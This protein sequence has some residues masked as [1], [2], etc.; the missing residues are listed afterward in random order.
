MKAIHSVLIACM[1][2]TSLAPVARADDDDD[3]DGR[4]R[5]YAVSSEEALDLAAAYGLDW[6]KEIKRGNGNWEI[7]GCTYD[8]EEI[9]IDISGQSGG[10]VKLEYEDDD[11]C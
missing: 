4:Q 10:I 6:V 5:G 1:M 2:A 11:D 8:G 3:D 7:E 9:E